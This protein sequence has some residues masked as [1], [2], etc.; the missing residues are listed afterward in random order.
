MESI[1]ISVK[2]LASEPKFY[3]TPVALTGNGSLSKEVIDEK[4]EEYY[5]LM[6]KKEQ[7]MKKLEKAR[8]IQTEWENSPA[9]KAYL[10]WLKTPE[11]QKQILSCKSYF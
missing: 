7:D 1:K 5:Q 4:M 2:H 11:G 6:K 8:R 9:G 3:A 10:N